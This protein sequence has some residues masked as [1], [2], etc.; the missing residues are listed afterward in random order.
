MNN[1]WVKFCIDLLKFT[2]CLI[3]VWA[4]SMSTIAT[5]LFVLCKVKIL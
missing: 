3:V 4:I 5:I 1:E 2:A